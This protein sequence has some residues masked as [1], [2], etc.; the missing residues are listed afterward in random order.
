M[1]E[2]VFSA[3]ERPLEAIRDER[4]QRLHA[5][6]QAGRGPARWLAYER[7]RPEEI[8]YVLPDVALLER[9]QTN[10]E[11]LLQVRL[12]GEAVRMEGL[13]FVRGKS[14]ADFRPPWFRSH[15]LEIC[16]NA[17][18]RSA[19]LYATVTLHYRGGNYPYEQLFLPLVRRG[20]EPDCLLMAAVLPQTLIDLKASL[21]SCVG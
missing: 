6:W 13:G 20:P 19:P 16:G 5:Y 3:V 1:F 2:N 11:L 12:A 4:L 7:L 14:S 9:G 18:A 17:F 10:G 21:Q 15:M 8:A